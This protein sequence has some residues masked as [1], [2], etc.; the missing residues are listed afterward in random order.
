MPRTCWLLALVCLS[1]LT[2]RSVGGA[3]EHRFTGHVTA[4]SG[5]D[6]T[7]AQHAMDGNV[8]TRWSSAFTDDEWWQIAFGQPE[9]LAGLQIIWE[10]AYGEHYV[11]QVSDDGAQWHTVFEE[12]AGDGKTDWIFLRR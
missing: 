6:D 8:Q 9:R 4:S 11:I 10:Q 7:S 2:L 1:L 3:T 5:Q 12:A